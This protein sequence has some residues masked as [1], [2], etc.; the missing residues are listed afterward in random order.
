MDYDV[1][2]L[3]WNV[4]N[5][6]CD[7]NFNVGVPF[8]SKFLWHG[9]DKNRI[10]VR[11]MFNIESMFE[12]IESMFTKINAIFFYNESTRYYNIYWCKYMRAVKIKAIFADKLFPDNV[13]FLNGCIV[14]T[15]LRIVQ[16]LWQAG[17]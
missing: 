1:T 2:D 6:G 8:V 15:S 5:I 4:S 9:M 3:Q 7:H 12:K 14:C 11:K 10:D 17:K 16:V 13:H